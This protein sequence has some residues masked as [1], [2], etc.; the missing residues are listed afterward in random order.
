MFS[1]YSI[2]VLLDRTTTKQTT[3]VGNK[4]YRQNNRLQ[5][6]KQNE[7]SAAFLRTG[8]YLCEIQPR[9]IAETQ[10]IFQH[11]AAAAAALLIFCSY[12]FPATVLFSSQ[13][14]TA[15]KH[16]SM[17]FRCM[18]CTL[19]AQTICANSDMKLEPS[20]SKPY[21]IRQYGDKYFVAYKF[22]GKQWQTTPK[23]LPRIERTAAIPVA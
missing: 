15:E 13:F 14:K 8:L 7:T 12:F 11:T 18:H 19:S 23:N 3:S 21:D 20:Y 6:K 22:G 10:R 9:R 17:Q 2:L 5:Q 1:W 16:D 4:I